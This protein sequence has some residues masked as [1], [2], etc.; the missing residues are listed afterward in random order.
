MCKNSQI[1]RKENI[2][3]GGPHF[4]KIAEHS[5]PTNQHRIKS[6][7]SQSKVSE[8]PNQKNVIST[9]VKTKGKPS[10]EQPTPG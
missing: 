5:R 8:K 1:L 3:P 6:N 7:L 10:H 2:K 4:F 9:T